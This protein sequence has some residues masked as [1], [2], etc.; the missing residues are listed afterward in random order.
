MAG[1]VLAAEQLVGFSAKLGGVA[2]FPDVSEPRGG[3]QQ[4]GERRAAADEPPDD[5]RAALAPCQAEEEQDRVRARRPL[6]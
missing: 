1:V 5:F 3:D 6:G 2:E 4:H